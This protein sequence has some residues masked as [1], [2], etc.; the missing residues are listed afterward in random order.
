MADS[1]INNLPGISALQDANKFA[2]TQG[3]NT[4]GVTA[5]Q[6]KTHVLNNSLFTAS[7]LKGPKNNA[8]YSQNINPI[9]DGNTQAPVKY[10]SPIPENHTATTLDNGVTV[11]V[12]LL[13]NGPG[14]NLTIESDFLNVGQW[15]GLHLESS[16]MPTLVAGTDV[17]LHSLNNA[18]MGAGQY[19]TI[20][21]YKKALNTFLITGHVI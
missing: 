16:T 5:L 13:Y 2:A 19:G 7:D 9:F 8:D 12:M 6:I 15:A 20:G 17:V 3:G 18:L 1:T 4:V 11:N 21:I 14:G 10:V